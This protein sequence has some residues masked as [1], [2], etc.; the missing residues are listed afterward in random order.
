MLT[1]DKY[2][3]RNFSYVRLI[4]IECFLNCKINLIHD[5]T[6]MSNDRVIKNVISNQKAYL[7]LEKVVQ[8]KPHFRTRSA[9]PDLM[10]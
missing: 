10:S 3:I 2:S 1:K 6:Q 9:G 5:D 7:D 4:Q 8:K